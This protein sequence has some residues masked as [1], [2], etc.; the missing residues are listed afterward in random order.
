MI[1]LTHK[2]LEPFFF[3]WKDP[4]ETQQYFPTFVD[5]RGGKPPAILAEGLTPEDSRL[6]LVTS[7]E[8]REC[9][10]VLPIELT[11]GAID[12]YIYIYGSSTVDKS[13]G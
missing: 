7:P 5:G 1:V 9:A 6:E 4:R 12:L 10:H 13:L 11:L 8:P 3:R 2:T